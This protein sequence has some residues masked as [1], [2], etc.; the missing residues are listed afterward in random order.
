MLTENFIFFHLGD[1]PCL[2]TWDPDNK[3]YTWLTYN[4]V[5]AKMHCTVMIVF[6]RGGEGSG[7]FAVHTVV[8][9]KKW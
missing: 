2:G 4:Q 6:R 3:K 1:G 5:S 7:D 9:F 8:G